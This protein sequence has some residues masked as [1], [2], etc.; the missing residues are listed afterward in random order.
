MA[1]RDLRLPTSLFSMDI[2]AVH[3]LAG[4]VGTFMTGM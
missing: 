4:I 3:A 1:G 2:F